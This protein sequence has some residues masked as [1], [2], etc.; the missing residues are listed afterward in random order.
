MPPKAYKTSL[1]QNKEDQSERQEQLYK[2]IEEYIGNN[3]Y[4]KYEYSTSKNK[5]ETDV[6]VEG[7]KYK[8]VWNNMINAGTA[9]EI[10]SS[11]LQDHIMAMRQNLQFKYVRIWDLYS[12]EMYID[13]NAKNK[14][15]N[16]DKLNRVLDIIVKNNLYPYI[17]L[18]IKP[19]NY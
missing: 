11:N 14:Y 17:D 8:K 2:R 13:I 19:N 15:Y 12:P 7:R 1:M 10:L 4:E 5:I 16:F 18:S 3:P 9:V 6:K